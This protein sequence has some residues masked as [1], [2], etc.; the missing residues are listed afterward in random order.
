MKRLAFSVVC[1]HTSYNNSIKK[2]RPNNS[3]HN[4]VHLAVEDNW[5]LTKDNDPPIANFQKISISAPLHCDM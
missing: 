4:E 3:A 1:F 5:K 2:T